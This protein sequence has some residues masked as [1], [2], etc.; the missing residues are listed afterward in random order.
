MAVKENQKNQNV[1]HSIYGIF[2]NLSNYTNE[3]N[4]KKFFKFFFDFEINYFRS[5]NLTELEKEELNKLYKIC[6]KT[7]LNNDHS[8]V[9]L[10][11]YEICFDFE[12]RNLNGN[13]VFKLPD[14]NREFVYNFIKKQKYYNIY[15]HFYYTKINNDYLISTKIVEAENNFKDFFI[16][17]PKKI[18]NKNKNMLFLR[19]LAIYS[20]I[21]NRYFTS[22][23]IENSKLPKYAYKHKFNLNISDK[24]EIFKLINLINSN[25]ENISHN[26]TQKISKFIEINY[27]IELEY[28]YIDVVNFVKDSSIARIYI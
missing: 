16:L 11:N 20:E 28:N 8:I 14:Y 25:L 17:I 5:A 18:V 23:Y 9:N 13:Y 24:E 27:Q 10:E 21:Y 6:D 19:I 1:F 2:L 22:I 4:F 12:L 26:Y 3:L 7:I 15:E